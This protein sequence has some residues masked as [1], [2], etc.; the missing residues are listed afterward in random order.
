MALKQVKDHFEEIL[1]VGRS[2]IGKLSGL[3][4]NVL[5][6]LEMGGP[7]FVTAIRAGA[8]EIL[9]ANFFNPKANQRKYWEQA[10]V[11]TV[12]EVKSTMK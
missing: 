3:G 11:D 6:D 9:I 5:L 4:D 10:V 12:N 1:R 8:E 2:Q 7:K